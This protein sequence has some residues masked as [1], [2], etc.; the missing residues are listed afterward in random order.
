MS[1]RTIADSDLA[2]A[3]GTWVGRTAVGSVGGKGGGSGALLENGCRGQL[4]L[5][6]SVWLTPGLGRGRGYKRGKGLVKEGHVQSEFVMFPRVNSYTIAHPSIHPS[7]QPATCRPQEHVFGTRGGCNSI[8]PVWAFTY[9]AD[10]PS[11]HPSSRPSLPP[12]LH[13][14]SQPASQPA[15]PVGPRNMK[16]AMGR[17]GSDS[18]ARLRWIASD[19]AATAVS[20]PTTRLRGKCGKK[21]WRQGAGVKVCGDNRV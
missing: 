18:P 6:S 11:I 12:S 3:C 10:Q 16:L 8:P 2:H 1:M 20:W 4:S 5:A 14:A 15:S 7:S 21:V 13:A 19:T 9:T 17:L